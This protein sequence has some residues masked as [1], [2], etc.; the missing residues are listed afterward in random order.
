MTAEPEIESIKPVTPAAAAAI[1]KP[2]RWY[3]WAG[4]AATL[5]YLAAI[6]AFGLARGGDFSEL[7]LNELG[8]FL[9]GVF[10]PLAFLWLVLGYLQQ[11]DE[12]KQ[13]TAALKLQ[14]DE[15]A[16]SVEQQRE[17]VKAAW[18]QIEHARETDAQERRHQEDARS[19][20]FKLSTGGHGTHGNTHQFSLKLSNAGFA[21]RDIRVE[22]P[23]VQFRSVR[24][25]THIAE[26]QVKEIEFQTAEMSEVDKGLQ[27]DLVYVDGTNRKKSS[28][29][30]FRC[31]PNGVMTI[32]RLNA[33]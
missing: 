6:A 21:A 1:P 13:N 20:D 16:N 19:A 30:L 4:I 33:T 25:W 3:T 28:S 12:L 14:A 32:L 23:S 7:K 8:D 26:G 15:L 27:V 2:R 24:D 31:A 11:G 18:A 10:A 29:W 9:S 5:L 22:I 17:M